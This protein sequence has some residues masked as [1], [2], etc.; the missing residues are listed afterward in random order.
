M[1]GLEALNRLYGHIMGT[2]NYYKQFLSSTPYINAD[3]E[4]IEKELKDGEKYKKAIEVIKKK[5]DERRIVLE[6]NFDNKFSLGGL[7]LCDLT[8]DELATIL[9][10]F[11]FENI[12][13]VDGEIQISSIRS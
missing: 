5:V 7:E 1:N 4:L 2:S 11:D 9:E 13:V 3:K 6:N 8:Y 12:K 10:C